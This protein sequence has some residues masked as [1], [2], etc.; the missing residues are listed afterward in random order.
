MRK[1]RSDIEKYLE[2][3][4]LLNPVRQGADS[5]LSHHEAVPRQCSNPSMTTKLQDLVRDV[6]EIFREDS[7]CLKGPEAFSLMLT[8]LESLETQ[9][10]DEEAT[11]SR[12]AVKFN[13]AAKA[14]G[15]GA[16]M[17]VAAQ[18]SQKPASPCYFAG[19]QADR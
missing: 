4:T 2:Y 13:F 8:Q 7:K 3:L 9:L 16:S 17:T 18:T 11:Q 5:M 12:K 14:G 1:H 15:G 10:R 6:R 19:R